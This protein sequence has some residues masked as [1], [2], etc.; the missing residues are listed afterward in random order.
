MNIEH[1]DSTVH[2]VFLLHIA[3]HNV[4]RVA[5]DGDVRNTPNLSYPSH[6]TY[7]LHDID[8]AIADDCPVR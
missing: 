5:N 1:L 8:H 4:S 7:T 2:S 3:L 6:P